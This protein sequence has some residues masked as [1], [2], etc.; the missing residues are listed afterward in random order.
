MSNY[1]LWFMQ[2]STIIIATFIISRLFKIPASD[3]F[4]HK[5]HPIIMIFLYIS[6]SEFKCVI[7]SIPELPDSTNKSAAIKI[8]LWHPRTE[9][10][11]TWKKI[12]PSII[13]Q[14]EGGVGTVDIWLLCWIK[15]RRY[16][17]LMWKLHDIIFVELLYRNSP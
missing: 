14:R 17:I 1:A 12:L 15:L 10:C 16:L 6:V 5:R 4:W 11:T 2:I 9:R 3:E 7:Y 8:I 13:I